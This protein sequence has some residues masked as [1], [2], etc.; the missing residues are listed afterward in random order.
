MK[1][2]E[3]FM[4][5]LWFGVIF[6]LLILAFTVPMFITKKES[7]LKKIRVAEVT[8]SIFYAPQYAAIANGY[9]EETGLDIELILT[10]GADKVMASVL[11]GDVEI[12]LS[13][14]E[15]TIYVS[16]G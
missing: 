10:P 16:V 2:K 3:E 8:H 11:S 9:F 6:T 5:K 4:R 15:A 7:G 12:G 14:S 1:L 13:G